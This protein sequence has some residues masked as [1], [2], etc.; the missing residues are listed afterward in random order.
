MCIF[1]F[2]TIFIWTIVF[3]FLNIVFIFLL[4]MS[5]NIC[6]KNFKKILNNS[7]NQI[8]IEIFNTYFI[9]SSKFDCFLNTY[10]SFLNFSKISNALNE[11]LNLIYLIFWYFVARNSELTSIIILIILISSTKIACSTRFITSK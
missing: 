7:R 8:S 4:M 9:M 10:T 5:R 11:I 1:F 3:R 6:R 2:F